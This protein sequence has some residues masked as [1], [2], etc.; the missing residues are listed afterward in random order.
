MC[1]TYSKYGSVHPLRYTGS[2][3]YRI[4][5]TKVDTNVFFF[6]KVGLINLRTKLRTFPWGSPSSPI[7]MEANQSRGLELWSD[8][9][10]NTQTKITTLYIWM[11]Q[12]KILLNID[13]LRMHRIKFQ[14]YWLYDLNELFMIWEN[15]ATLWICMNAT[16]LGICLVPDS[17]C[18]SYD[19]RGRI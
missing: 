19:F 8:K 15:N 13:Y 12:I 9:Q 4:S 1:Q 2:R 3:F 5:N 10:T 7:K 14:D 6:I 16:L 18:K 17:Q 11:K